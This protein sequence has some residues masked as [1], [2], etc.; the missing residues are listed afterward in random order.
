[1]RTCSSNWWAKETPTLKGGGMQEFGGRKGK[2]KMLRLKCNLK[3]KPKSELLKKKSQR[4]QRQHCF[5]SRGLWVCIAP[6][7]SCGL[8]GWWGLPLSESFQENRHRLIQRCSSDLIPGPTKMT[9]KISHHSS[10]VEN[11]LEWATSKCPLT[12]ERALCRTAAQLQGDLVTKAKDL[13]N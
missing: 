12:R 10:F 5:S 4:Q 8:S 1:M 11:R 13:T 2:G 9:T 3:N 7:R 6:R